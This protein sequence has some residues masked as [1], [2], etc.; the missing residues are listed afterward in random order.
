MLGLEGGARVEARTVVVATGARYRRLS[1]LGYARLE[2]RGIWYAAAPMEAQL[3]SDQEV[4][5]V[6]GGNSAGQAAVFLSR[7]CRHVHVLVR[8][9]GLAATMSDY[10]VQRI[11]ASPSITLRPF[12]EVMAVAGEQ[13]LTELTWTDRRTGVSE[14]RRMGG[15]FVMIGADPN[16]EWLHGCVPT[17]PRGFIVTGRADDGTPL[18]SPYATSMPGFSLWGTSGPARSS[19]SL[20][21]SA[22]V[23]S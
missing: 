18:A 9:E 4:V 17:D 19:A 8:A 3:C 1:V 20:R 2:G 16:T 12:T 7:T 11:V 5:V 21:A 10:L 13:E 14:T 6:G 15:L 22:K 23:R